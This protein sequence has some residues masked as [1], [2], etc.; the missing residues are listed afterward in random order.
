MR[1]DPLLRAW[2]TLCTLSVGGAVLTGMPG[3]AVV[4][5]AILGVALIKTRLILHHYLGLAAAPR[6][7]RGFDLAATGLCLL[8]AALGIAAA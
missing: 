5:V 8:L 1:R 2:A 7:R 6:W 4:S 3:Q